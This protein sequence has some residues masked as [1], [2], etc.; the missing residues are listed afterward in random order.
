MLTEDS[1]GTVADNSAAKPIVLENLDFNEALRIL[2]DLNGKP[3]NPPNVS[4]EKLSARF[5]NRTPENATKILEALKS[6]FLE[7]PVATYRASDF[8][9]E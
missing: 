4:G 1:Q 2:A 6:Y 3:S 8:T 9:V 5:V 7:K